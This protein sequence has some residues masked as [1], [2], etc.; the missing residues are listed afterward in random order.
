MWWH[1]FTL[2]LYWHINNNDNERCCYFYYCYKHINGK[3]LN[4]SL[5]LHLSRCF[6][7]ICLKSILNF[8]VWFTDWYFYIPTIY[9]YG[10]IIILYSLNIFPRKTFSCFVRSF[11]FYSF[12]LLN[13]EIHRIHDDFIDGV[14]ISFPCVLNKPK[15]V[16][17]VKNVLGQFMKGSQIFR[18]FQVLNNILAITR[19][20]TQKSNLNIVKK[21]PPR[22]WHFL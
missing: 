18:T 17:I 7:H 13:H 12:S 2:V 4:N 10:F 14:L 5:L 16:F 11:S 8:Y 22:L 19:V 20:P 9:L 3:T 1:S 6:H 21:N 15:I